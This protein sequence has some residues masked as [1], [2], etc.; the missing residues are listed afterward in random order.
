M[1]SESSNKQ[2]EFGHDLLG[3]VVLGYV[4]SLY[5]TLSSFEQTRGA[6]ILYATRAGV[7]IKHLIDLYV[8]ARGAAPLQTAELFY[9]SRLVAS[10][11][12]WSRSP[13]RSQRLLNSI[14]GWMQPN[15]F[16]T[17]MLRQVSDNLATCDCPGV[18]PGKFDVGAFLRSNDDG[19]RQVSQH[20][21]HQ[22][23]LFDRYVSDLAD[24]ANSM[25]LVDTGWQGTTQAILAESFEN[26]D[27]WGVY[28][29]RSGF[30]D[31]DRSHWEKMIGLVFEDDFFVPTRPASAISL[32]RHMIE[33]LFEP[34]APSI[35]AFH[36]V[37][38]EVVPVGLEY[39][40]RPECLGEGADEIYRGVAEFIRENARTN[41]VAEIGAN[42]AGAA[43]R[44][45]RF[46]I[47]PTIDEL[48]VYDTRTRSA[49]FG[50]D[51][52]VSV[53]HEPVARN[54][55]DS[56][57]KRIKD[58]L[59]SCGQAA[60]EYKKEMAAPIQRQ[61]A[62]IGRGVFSR[63]GKLISVPPSF[64]KQAAWPAVAV[65]TRTLDRP[66]FL[67]R[68]LQS[69]SSQ[70]FT[71]YLHV[72]VNDGGDLGIAEQ[73][74][75]TE[76]VD[77]SR[78]VLADTITNRGMEAASNIGISAIHSKYIVIHDDDDSWEPDFLKKAVDFLEA[79]S[80]GLY[81]GVITGTTYVSELVDADGIH[82]KG[83][84]PYQAWVDK[85]DVMEMSVGNFFAPIAFLFKREIYD[86]IGGYD[87]RYP[88]L[89]DWDFNLRFLNVANIGVVKEPLANYHHR[90]VGDTVTFGNSVIAGRDKHVEFSAIVRNEF[91]RRGSKLSPQFA[92]MVLPGLFNSEIRGRV[93][94]IE[95]Y[96]HKLS[97]E[98]IRT[99][100]AET[101]TSI[102][103]DV[104]RIWVSLAGSTASS[105]RK[106]FFELRRR[107]GP[108]VITS[109]EFE[110][111]VD[112]DAK[113]G[114]EVCP[115]FDEDAYLDINQDV[116]IAVQRGEIRNGYTHYVTQGRREGR[117]RPRRS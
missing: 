19:A 52:K 72:I 22:E 20:F 94:S 91:A 8:D 51:I 98:P 29:G 17:A 116:K 97:Q 93:R 71:D 15:E 108:R 49:D 42:A 41:S 69:V 87:E 102:N 3:P 40:Q 106:K 109:A 44:L 80:T 60:V 18:Q 100:K 36:E 28:F 114:F 88:V 25:V 58:A 65:I 67:R 83:R 37:G 75:R 16:A 62:G 110:G 12:C 63:D 78:I 11:A 48:S 95:Q 55:S 107:E 4:S 115:T 104:D 73:A 111:L 103:D 86:Q 112:A 92:S 101:V 24:G 57:D 27:W 85:V 7:R 33:D 5:A 117:I 38:D 105:T 90:D 81:G 34:D 31:S 30:A 56:S 14:F 2:Y 89:G 61:I 45:A 82:I 46:I 96:A 64:R 6:K 84:T 26:W 10:K 9:V 79:D 113:N 59:W 50:R 32:H 21:A 68:A 1:G 39:Y 53:L 13:D 99:T 66:T 77:H 74:I 43:K 54:D 70:T 47:H 76:L 35:E 23:E